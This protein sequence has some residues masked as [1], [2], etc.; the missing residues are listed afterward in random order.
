VDPHGPVEGE[1]TTLDFGVSTDDGAAAVDLPFAFPFGG[2]AYDKAFV[3]TNGAVSFGEHLEDYYVDFQTTDYRGPGA[4]LSEFT[5]AVFPYFTDLDTAPTGAPGGT[6]TVTRAA[7][8]SVAMRWQEPDHRQPELRRDVQAV[9]F[10]DGRIRFDYLGSDEETARATDFA[11]VGLSTGTGREAL[12]ALTLGARKP[13]SRS[14]LYTP[15][16]VAAASVPQGLARIVTPRATSFVSADAGCSL[17]SEATLIS[18]GVVECATPALNPGESRS[19]S[20]RYV[21]AAID[22]LGQNE[23]QH[24]TA[25][26]HVGE[27]RLQ[28]AEEGDLAGLTPKD[29]DIAVQITPA[30]MTV[31]A[32]TQQTL[33]YAASGDRLA[34]PTLTLHIP[35]GMEAV[36]TTLPRCSALPPGTTGGAIVC[37]PRDGAG[38]ISG[39][40][41]VKAAPGTKQ[42]QA[43][44]DADNAFQPITGNW[45]VNGA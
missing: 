26:W 40:L 9:L 14:V 18:G 21:R 2:I 16:A 15:H 1:T 41:V 22:A 31:P 42:V 11:T 37:L 5:R 20:A 7:D 3:S 24:L 44:L 17:V 25:E 27:A 8:G 32:G 4:V 36:S 45:S 29:P 39:D 13:P 33:H 43:V 38:S 35:A 6:V 23:N 28:D 30:T 10:R 34:L 19:I 12:S